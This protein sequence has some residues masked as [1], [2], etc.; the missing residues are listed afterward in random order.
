M[1]KKPTDLTAVWKK[2]VSLSMWQA[3]LSKGSNLISGGSSGFST[4][5]VL[6]LKNSENVR[7]KM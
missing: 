3:N 6:H 4:H 1:K 5:F 7:K 2:L